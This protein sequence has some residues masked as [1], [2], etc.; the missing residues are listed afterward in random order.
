MAHSKHS[1]SLPTQC[2]ETKAAVRIMLIGFPDTIQK[3]RI[4]VTRHAIII[5]TMAMSTVVIISLIG[6]VDSTPASFVFT[7]HNC[8]TSRTQVPILHQERQYSQFVNNPHFF[9]VH[10]TSPPF[11]SSFYFL[12][13]T[14]PWLG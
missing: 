11:S 5:T 2:V 7:F 13:S 6:R 10:C 9:G 12:H 4:E 3:S 14:S 1:L 8:C